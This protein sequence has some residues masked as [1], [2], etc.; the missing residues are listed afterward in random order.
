MPSAAA[1][2]AGRAGGQKYDGLLG[3]EGGDERRR[4]SLADR[5]LAPDGARRGAGRRGNS[6]ATGGDGRGRRPGR[7][8]GPGRGSPRPRPVVVVAASPASHRRFPRLAVSEALGDEPR[9][10][11][12]R[13]R[14]PPPPSPPPPRPATAP[15]AKARTTGREQRTHDGVRRGRGR[16]QIRALI[17]HGSLLRCVSTCGRRGGEAAAPACRNVGGVAGHAL[18]ADSTNRSRPPRA[19]IDPLNRLTP[20]PDA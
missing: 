5:P 4:R 17:P 20:T 15:A 11:T 18:R 3:G 2:L 12:D 9:R 19:T 10:G 6:V 16:D 7:G 13:G 14:S 1:G 8:E